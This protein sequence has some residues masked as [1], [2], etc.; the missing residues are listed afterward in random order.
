MQ[1]PTSRWSDHIVAQSKLLQ[2]PGNRRSSSMCWRCYGWSRSHLLR[3]QRRS[4]RQQQQQQ[5]Q[6]LRSGVEFVQMARVRAHCLVTPAQECKIQ[7]VSNRESYI[8]YTCA[9]VCAISCHHICVS[10][11]LAAGTSFLLALAY[12]AN[13][14]LPLNATM[15]REKRRI[16]VRT[17]ARI[18]VRL[19]KPTMI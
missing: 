12:L 13:R 10:S 18:F 17:A 4:Q 2:P 7:G 15:P 19:H 6:Q 14:S 11:C 9:R 3:K 8:P 1:M 5:Q 16:L